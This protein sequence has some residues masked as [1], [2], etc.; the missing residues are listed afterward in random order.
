MFVP[1]PLLMAGNLAK[2]SELEGAEGG[3]GMGTATRGD[4]F[5]SHTPKVI[6]SPYNIDPTGPLTT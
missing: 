6:I 2:H 3:T 1:F 5:M 4:Y